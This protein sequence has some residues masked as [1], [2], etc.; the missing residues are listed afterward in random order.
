ML[1]AVKRVRDVHLEPQGSEKASETS[2]FWKVPFDS[3]QNDQKLGI[4]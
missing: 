4:E 3:C 2:G 1:I